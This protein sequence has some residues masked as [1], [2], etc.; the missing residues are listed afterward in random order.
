MTPDRPQNNT[1]NNRFPQFNSNGLYGLG[2]IGR[3]SAGEDEGR[4][5]QKP[6]IPENV[7]EDTQTEQSAHISGH[8][9]FGWRNKSFS[10]FRHT[11]EKSLMCNA[12]SLSRTLEMHIGYFTVCDFLVG[13]QNTVTKCGILYDVGDSYIVLFDDISN[14]YTVCD[15]SSLKFVTFLNSTATPPN[16]RVIR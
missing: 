12:G 7:N 14:R 5:F 15:S 6:T 1:S 16:F 3:I 8:K 9:G 2:N 4:V 13:T 11:A 10:G